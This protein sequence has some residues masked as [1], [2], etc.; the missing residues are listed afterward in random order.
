MRSVL[1]LH[2]EDLKLDVRRDIDKEEITLP[3]LLS[4]PW[5]EVRRFDMV[6]FV[7]TD[8]S[9]KV[10]KNRYGPEDEFP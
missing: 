8:K 10:L 5:A 2:R 7:D 9:F 4:A 1:F 6:I 3:D